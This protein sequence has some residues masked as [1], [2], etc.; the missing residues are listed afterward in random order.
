MGTY[1][2]DQEGQEEYPIKRL[3]DTT[4]WE[5]HIFP[6]R[7]T[8]SKPL[9]TPFYP[10]RA[11]CFSTQSFCLLVS[12]LTLANLMEG[13]ST[14]LNALMISQSTPATSYATQGAW[15]SI[16]PSFQFFQPTASGFQPSPTQKEFCPRHSRK[17]PKRCCSCGCRARTADSSLQSGR[18]KTH[19]A[20][21]IF[22]SWRGPQAAGWS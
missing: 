13:P 14:Q 6:R 2:Q 21:R 11:A 12:N 18:C 10:L 19:S 20:V 9:S 1:R 22:C 3:G 16:I 17:G 7:A 5:Q 4:A 8:H 15:I